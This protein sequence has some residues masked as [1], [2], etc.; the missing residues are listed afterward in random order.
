MNQ[1]GSRQ[2][3]PPPTRRRFGHGWD[4]IK[5][6]HSKIAYWCQCGYLARARRYIP[7]LE[8]CLR[9]ARESHEAILGEISWSLVAEFNGDIPRA[10][11]FR[12]HAIDMMMGWFARHPNYSRFDFEVMTYWYRPALYA[13]LAELQLRQGN[14]AAARRTLI[15]ARQFCDRLGLRFGATRM[16]RRLE[17]TDRCAVK[18]GARRGKR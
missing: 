15:R 7:R 8:A 3:A 9:A 1:R 16:L 18:K 10:V 5:Y 12:K 13:H 2:S 11:E 17:A 14:P 6:V 4:E